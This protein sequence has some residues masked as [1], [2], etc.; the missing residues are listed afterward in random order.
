ML[1]KHPNPER[2]E[3]ATS[4]ALAR[5]RDHM[6]RSDAVRHI[7][8]RLLPAGDEDQPSFLPEPAFDLVE[9]EA[10]PDIPPP[11]P[12]L[13]AGSDSALERTGQQPHRPRLW[14]LGAAAIAIVAVGGVAWLIYERTPAAP[15]S[16]KVPY[17]AADAAPEKIRPQ[18]E[19]GI[20]V[21]NQDIRVYNELAGSKPAKESE[22][23]LP[24][25][26]APMTPPAVTSAEPQ[27]TT[28]ATAVPSIP[29]PALDVAPAAGTVTQPDETS[30]SASA[31][32]E[33]AATATVTVPEP[34]QTAATT[35]AFRIQL[36]AVKTNDAAQ[37]AWKKMMKTHPDVLKGLKLNVVK[38]D[39][40]DGTLFRVQGGPFADRAAAE[41]ACG[42]LKQKSQACLVV[43]P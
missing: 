8:P 43:A 34:V 5:R 25:P 32:G 26:E 10:D 35:G 37:A 36:A 7:E 1:S 2:E 23:L 29:A 11:P 21:P 22:V 9:D 40:A 14:P 13:R 3:P 27:A 19:G 38:V 41:T 15:G 42:K 17:V 31:A 20:E 12:T 39:R 18:Q 33:P 16:G 24:P 4:P 30:V 6:L 28:E